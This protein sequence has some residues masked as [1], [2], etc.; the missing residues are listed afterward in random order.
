MIRLHFI[1][2]GQSEE[3][4]V[5]YALVDHLAH[6]HI[7]VNARRIRPRNLAR[8]GGRGG[9]ISYRQLKKDLGLWMKEDD[10]VESYFTTMFDLYG[11]PRDFP[12]WRPPIS[13]V[14]ARERVESLEEAFLKDMGHSRFIPYIHLHEFESLV[15]VDPP[16]LE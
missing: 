3:A 12:G 9:I 4:F 7:Y 10:N 2:E 13:G 16:V 14:S 11:L 5:Q 8:S 15:L 1:V 6:H